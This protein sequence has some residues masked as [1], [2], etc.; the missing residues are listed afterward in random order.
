MRFGAQRLLAKARW[1]LDKWQPLAILT[2]AF[3]ASQSITE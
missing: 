3:M 1:G 2:L